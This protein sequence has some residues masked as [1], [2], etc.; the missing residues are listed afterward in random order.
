MMACP[1]QKEEVCRL[2]DGTEVATGW[3]GKDTGRNY[4]N[5]C[6]CNSGPLACTTQKC[7]EPQP[8]PTGVPCWI[9]F[10][11]APKSKVH[12]HTNRNASEAKT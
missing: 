3:S 12:T 11:R 9:S 6:R 5:T 4:C 8:Q 2:G 1:P 7:D 10:S